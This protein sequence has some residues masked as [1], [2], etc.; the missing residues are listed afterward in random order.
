MVAN[1][2]WSSS[3][4]PGWGIFSQGGGNTR[5]NANGTS[6]TKQD[7]SGTPVVCDGT[8]HFVLTSFWRG[9]Y[10][11]VYVD[12]NLILNSPLTFNARWTR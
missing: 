2:S 12:G 4:N 10:A 8:W 6:G 5:V 1:K 7:T 3:G 9:Q 11:A